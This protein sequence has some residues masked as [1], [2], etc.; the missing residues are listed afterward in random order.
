MIGD[1]S[2]IHTNVIVFLVAD[3]SAILNMLSQQIDT[4]F[5]YSIQGL[6]LEIDAIKDYHFDVT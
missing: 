5:D 3:V 2:K 1:S 6:L 4:C